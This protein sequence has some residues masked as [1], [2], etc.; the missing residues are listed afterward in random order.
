MM[1]NQKMS[2][3]AIFK[4]YI[5]NFKSTLNSK[6]SEKDMINLMKKV[7]KCAKDDILYNFKGEYRLKT[8]ANIGLVN[9]FTANTKRPPAGNIREI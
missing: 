8:D 3:D 6:G 5:Q 7:L 1:D 2:K 9:F 4:K